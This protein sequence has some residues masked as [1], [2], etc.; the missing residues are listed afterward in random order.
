MRTWSNQYYKNAKIS[1]FKDYVIEIHDDDDGNYIILVALKKKK[2]YFIPGLKKLVRIWL[3][4]Q[5]QTF[6]QLKAVDGT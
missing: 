5:C 1:Y 4:L 3:W 6:F 2:N